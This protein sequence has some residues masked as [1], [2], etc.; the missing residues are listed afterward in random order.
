MVMPGLN[1]RLSLDRLGKQLLSFVLGWPAPDVN[2]VGAQYSACESS[3]GVRTQIDRHQRAQ[4]SES[5]QIVIHERR[6]TYVSFDADPID[7]VLVQDLPDV[8]A[9]S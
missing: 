6:K 2:P 9:Q 8:I 5:A 4:D 7:G 1:H 3:T